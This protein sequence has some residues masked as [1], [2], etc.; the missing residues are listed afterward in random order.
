MTVADSRWIRRMARGAGFV[1]KMRPIHVGSWNRGAIFRATIVVMSSSMLSSQSQNRGYLMHR[2]AQAI[3]QVGKALGVEIEFMA[4]DLN[5]LAGGLLCIWNPSVFALSSCCCNRNFILLAELEMLGR[6]YIWYNAVER[7]KW[8]KIDR[9]L[10]SPEW[11]LMFKVKVWGLS[12]I[13]SDH[14][15]LVL[16]EDTRDWGPRPFRFINAWVLHPQFISVVKKAW[17]ETMVS[18]WAG[19]RIF[20]KLKAVKVS[21]KQWN[22]EVFGDINHKLK[23]SKEKLHKL[24]LVVEIRDLDDDEL[25]RRMEHRREVLKWRKRNEWLWLQKSRVSWTLKGDKKSKFFHSIA[26]CRQNN[27]SLNSLT[28]NAIMIEDPVKIKKEVFRHFKCLFLEFWKVRPKLGGVFKSSRSN[29]TKVELEFAFSESEIWAAVK[30]CNDC[31]SIL[32]VPL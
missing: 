27:N 13:V 21:L 7:E 25:G 26:S 23:A 17:E 19:Y 16:M 8:S 14:C 2:E 12:R 6:K 11:L 10:L 1:R 9:F 31:P 4:V 15:L 18:G 24:D 29:D 20:A 5:G 28:V 22:L 32:L 3:V 30:E